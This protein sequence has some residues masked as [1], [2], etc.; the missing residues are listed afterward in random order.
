MKSRPQTHLLAGDALEG[1]VR[2][3]AAPEQAAPQPGE[4]PTTTALKYMHVWI[5]GS[6]D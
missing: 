4:P 1:P 3:L 2:P 5:D 6:L